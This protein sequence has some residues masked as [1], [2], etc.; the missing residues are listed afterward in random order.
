VAL[1]EGRS[2]AG[3]TVQVTGG[4]LRVRIQLREGARGAIEALQQVGLDVDLILEEMVLG[5]IEVAKLAAL[6]EL[7]AVVRISAG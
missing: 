6:A 7:E 5:E 2:P 3:S 4:R 1:L